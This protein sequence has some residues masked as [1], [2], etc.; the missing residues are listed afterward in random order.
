MGNFVGYPL[1][2]DTG[3]GVASAPSGNHST[4][5]W[6]R[7]PQGPSSG[8][9]PHVPLNSW[10]AGFMPEARGMQLAGGQVGVPQH[11]QSATPLEY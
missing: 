10:E 8:V 7:V 11:N 2:M 4:E 9:Q 6:V 3:A 1:A 5:S